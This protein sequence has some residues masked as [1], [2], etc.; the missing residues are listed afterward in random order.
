MSV[1]KVMKLWEEIDR[2]LKDGNSAEIKKSKG[3]VVVVEIKRK[4]KIKQTV[5]TG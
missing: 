5:T 2:I 4:V 1:D 3:E